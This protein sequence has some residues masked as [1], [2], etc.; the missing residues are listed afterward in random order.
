MTQ[1]VTGHCSDEALIRVVAAIIGR[2]PPADRQRIEAAEA[3]ADQAGL[4]LGTRAQAS[5]D[6]MRHQVIGEAMARMGD[7]D[8]AIITEAMVDAV[9][10]LPEPNKATISE[11]VRRALMP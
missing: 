8:K 11:P 7:H 1:N 10:S 9:L 2:L 3:Q 5:A 4:H 6:I